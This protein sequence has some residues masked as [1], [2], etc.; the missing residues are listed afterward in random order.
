MQDV[1]EEPPAV[2]VERDPG[3]IAG[4]FDAQYQHAGQNGFKNSLWLDI[5]Q[6]FQIEPGMI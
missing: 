6:V 3:L 5:I 4:G 2:V 1:P